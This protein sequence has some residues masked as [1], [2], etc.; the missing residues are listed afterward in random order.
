MVLQL[1]KIKIMLLQ[2]QG[3][4]TTF[5]IYLKKKQ[6]HTPIRHCFSQTPVIKD[7]QKVKY[8]QR[9]TLCHSC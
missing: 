5:L 2:I 7:D 3:C 8:V 4:F 9:R 1:S 6:T